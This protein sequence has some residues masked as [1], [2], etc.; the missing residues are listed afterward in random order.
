MTVSQLGQVNTAALI[1]PGV[2]TQIVPPAPTI[3][4]GVQTN[5]SGISGTGS[6]GPLNSP[7][8]VGSPGELLATFG[9]VNARKY[10]L[11]TAATIQMQQ[12][13]TNL[14]CVR[15]S[16]GTDTA[17]TVAIASATGTGSGTGLT[18]TAKYSG[19][20]GNGISFTTAPGAAANSWA[21]TVSAPNMTPE[22]YSNITGS[23]AALWANIVAAINGG[24]SGL[25]GPSQIIVATAGAATALPVA[26]TTNL[27]GGTDGV[28]TITAATL[29]GQDT[30]PRKGMY[31]LRGQIQGGI[32][33]LADAD[34]STQWTAQAAFSLSEGVYVI[35]T[36]PSGDS[37]TNAVTAK[38]TA[39]IDCYGFKLMFGDWVYWYDQTN[40]IYR[41]VSPPAFI[42][43]LL[44]N[45]A[46]NQSSLNKPLNYVV[47]TQKTAGTST[48][49]TNYTQADL[50]QLALAGISV[51]G[52]PSPGGSYFSALL[53]RNSSS[54]PTIRGDNYTR[55]TNFIAYSLDAAYGAFIGAPQTPDLEA[56][57]EATG[58]LF[59]LN[60]FN[61]GLLS[62]V[63]G[64]QPWSV[65]CNSTNNPQS[66]QAL[67]DMIVA[68]QVIY[69]SIVENLIANIQGGQ[70]VTITRVS[71]QPLAA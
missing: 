21:V 36:G 47:G 59:F 68:I 15:V 63:N 55:M 56:E 43:G 27:S 30:L 10:D 19:V 25:R 4:A 29:I 69:Q 50:T 40:S 5:A 60:M 7:Q 70:T 20:L 37:I 51:I 17:A 31:A 23:G 62:L 41:Y 39:G 66:S 18:A 11:V 54:N 34:D 58:D 12:G 35:G 22:Y 3:V 44:A 38:A 24:Q 1:V 6:W 45:L 48:G 42:A 64:Q 71:A 49:G 32:C 13:A 67:G 33:M 61:Q 26:A 8:P 2:I 28:A 9:P 46:P 65:I 14:Q 53:G 16:D 52:N 57:A